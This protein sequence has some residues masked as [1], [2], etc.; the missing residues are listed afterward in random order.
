M[1]EIR[2]PVVH[3]DRLVKTYGTKDQVTVVSDVSFS[4]HA[5]RTLAIVGESGAGKSTIAAILTGLIA[6]SGGTV[7]V[8]GEDRTQPARSARVRRRRG[9]QLQL[10]SQD[11]FTSLDP[12]QPIGAVIMEALAIDGRFPR[13]NRR[14]RTTQ[15]LEAVGLSE[16]HAGVT[17]RLL[18]GGQRQRVAIARALAAGPEVIV[19]DEAVSALDVSVQAQVLNLLRDLQRDT[20]TAY[21]FITHDL[22]VVRQIAH[23]VL[24]LEAGRIVEQGPVDDV[25][26]R[27]RRDY[28][29]LLLNS[30][31]R[32]GWKPTP[33]AHRLAIE[34]VSLGGPA[35]PTERPLGQS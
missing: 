16:R 6:A 12:R 18:S 17:P 11:P 32:H 26:S 14:A 10:V 2:T 30:T 28:T 4:L 1:T 3:A 27:P 21:L 20:D 7:Q 34:E 22:A 9:R 8:C 24:V 33:R 35:H 19:L 5:G 15:L 25:L 31:P 23:E 29:K 13:A